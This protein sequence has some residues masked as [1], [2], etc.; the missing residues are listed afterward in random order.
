MEERLGDPLNADGVNRWQRGDQA[1][2]FALQGEIE[3]A[4]GSFEE[5]VQLFE[6]A[7][8]ILDDRF[9]EPLALSFWETGTPNGPWS[10]FSII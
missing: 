8:S 3:L 6:N 5:A 2:H 1:E 10:I 9:S 4:R 7:K